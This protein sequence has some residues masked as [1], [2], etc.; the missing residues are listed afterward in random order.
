MYFFH[1]LHHINTD[2]LACYV[3]SISPRRAGLCIQHTPQGGLG[4]AISM[5]RHTIWGEPFI[6]KVPPIL[7]IF[8]ASIGGMENRDHQC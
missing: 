6:S 8:D 7:R 5:E 1:M 3:Y 2:I 4:A